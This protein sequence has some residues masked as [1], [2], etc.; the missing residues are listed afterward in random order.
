MM[1]GVNDATDDADVEQVMQPTHYVQWVVYTQPDSYEY[2]WISCVSQ[3]ATEGP[4]CMSCVN[5]SVTEE[6]SCMSC[7]MN[8]IPRLVAI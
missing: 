4:S 1:C 5:Q 7:A 8:V 3:S 6:S 2:R